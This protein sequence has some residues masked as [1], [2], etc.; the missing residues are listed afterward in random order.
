MHLKIFTIL[1]LLAAIP[2]A[3][4]SSLGLE[5]LVQTA[6]ANNRDL[7][8][9]RFAVFKAKGRLAQ[10]GKWINPELELSGMSDVVFANDRAGA[11]TIG[12]SQHL[13]MTARLS[14]SRE[15]AR[16]DI[17]RAI[18]EIRNHERLLIAEVRSTSVRILQAEARARAL[19]S[20]LTDANK[21]ASLAEERLGAGQG[22]LAE[23]GLAL[24]DQ[25]LIANKLASARL[26]GALATMKLKTLLGL[27]A[28]TPLRI[29]ESLSG[30][31][32]KL[33]RVV[34][35]TPTTI[36][37]PDVD[38]LALEEE[39]ATIEI[40]LARAEAWEGIR[41]G[42]EYTYDRN[43]DAPEGLGTDHFLGLSV[44]IPLP[45]WDQNK[46]L[47]EER[48][49]MRD[50]SRAR[51]RAATLEMENA[52]ASSL[53][54]VNLLE[55][56]LAIFDR[57]TLPPVESALKDMSEGFQTGLVD[58]RDLLTLSQQLG[59][60]RLERIALQGRLANALAE[61]ESTTGAHPAIRRNYLT[62]ETSTKTQ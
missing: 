31:I 18:R 11:F 7:Q 39:K 59:E 56:R 57:E 27:E 9:A 55:S 28:K 15:S 12:L 53:H 14:L 4:A 41:I 51:L 24:V 58:L 10:A 38:L 36:H 8:A 3:P 23:K 5:S 47:M 19:D 25:R 32:E 40:A 61:L 1:A 2:G 54:R 34:T 29:S 35:P 46:G 43:I 21:T 13:P 42:I 37:R 30:A 20:L 49:A 52:L 44:S 45:L 22:S 50:E 60:L 26:D 16:V 48:S 62:L 17:L 33:S 6:L